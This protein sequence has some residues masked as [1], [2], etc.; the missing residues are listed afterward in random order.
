MKKQDYISLIA[1]GLTNEINLQEAET[2]KSMR[3]SDQVF[4]STYDELQEIWD[5]A[6]DYTPTVTFDSAVAYDKFAAKYQIPTDYNTSSSSNFKRVLISAV[7]AALLISS[8]VFVYLNSTKTD[9]VANDSTK[10]ETVV[11][12]QDEITLSPGA[13]IAFNED[14]SV[15][16]VVGNAYFKDNK[17]ITIDLNN[18]AIVSEGASFNISKA[19]GSN[20]LRVDVKEGSLAFNGN[21]G[22]NETISQNNSIVYDINT[23]SYE[24][25]N[26][27]TS[28]NYLLWTSNKLSF[29][30]TDIDVVFQE[31]EKFFG[32]KIN[33]E[34]IVPSDCSFTAPMVQHTSV[35]SIF[36]ILRTAF[37][38]NVTQTGDGEFEVSSIS[39][40][41]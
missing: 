22:S 32:V 26:A 11:H 37:E 31:M 36:E 18:G 29:N 39:C 2:L 28:N 24:L 27:T 3:S 5:A 38:F 4:S 20:K 10:I 25:L 9:T 19:E 12:N 15:K 17:D 7:I 14:G 16:D 1:K 8:S 21:D 13:E 30:N 34:G 33:V 23:G 41:K 35:S 40:Q 6:G